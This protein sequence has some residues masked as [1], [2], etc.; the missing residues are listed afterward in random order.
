MTN[1]KQIISKSLFDSAKLLFNNVKDKLHPKTKNKYNDLIN[2]NSTSSNRNLNS[3]KKLNS[4]LS[5]FN[6][7]KQSKNLSN[8][9]LVEKKREKAI[10]KLPE[11]KYTE[12]F[13]TGGINKAITY[14]NI[15]K[16]LK[17]RKN[18]SVRVRV[19]KTEVIKATSKAHAEKLFNDKMIK[20]NQDMLIES[21]KITNQEII[22]IFIDDI[23]PIDKYCG[24]NTEDMFMRDVKNH[25][26]YSF[27]PANDKLCI[28]ENMCVP[29]QFVAKYGPL[30]KN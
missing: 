3:L 10:E 7:I 17:K 12:F 26:G 29:D 30:I 1:Q 18:E 13:I 21:D 2:H 23:T 5:F 19:D 28:N 27:I 6:D 25:K 24:I 4:E 16:K 9:D 15:N 8:K 14:E 22:D 11:V 20:M